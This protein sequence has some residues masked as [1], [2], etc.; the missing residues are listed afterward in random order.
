MLAAAKISA[1]DDRVPVDRIG[2]HGREIGE[3]DPLVAAAPRAL[4]RECPVERLA[5]RP[6]E[7]GEDQKD[8]RRDQR[9]AEPTAGED[10]RAF[11]L[12]ALA[13]RR[14]D[15]GERASAPSGRLAPGKGRG[16]IDL[17]VEAV[18]RPLR[19]A[20][21]PC[22]SPRSGAGSRC[23]ARPL[24]RA[25][26]APAVLVGEDLLQAVAELA[27][28]LQEVAE[29]DAARAVAGVLDDQLRDGVSRPL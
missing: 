2:E 6:V 15:A 12:R 9:D 1:A 27:A 14:K 3:P 21:C 7:E 18:T 4:E 8:L 19:A 25:P 28:D 29:A 22:R 26:A 23:R 20:A 11:R 17:S 5:R 10:R 24:R 16:P 13:L